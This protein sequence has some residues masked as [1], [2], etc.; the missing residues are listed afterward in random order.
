[1]FCQMVQNTIRVIAKRNSEAYS[2][3]NKKVLL[4][5]CSEKDNNYGPNHKSVL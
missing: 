4:E 1:M 3:V 5:P 2:V